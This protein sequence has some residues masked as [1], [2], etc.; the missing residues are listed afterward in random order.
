MC[1]I[2]SLSYYE[3]LLDLSGK[4]KSHTQNLRLRLSHDG[5]ILSKKKNPCNLRNAHLLELSRCR[6]KTYGFNM[7]LLKGAFLWN[8]LPNDF[9]EAK[10]LMHFKSKIWE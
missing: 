10:S 7:I 3:E 5:V 4:K 1:N 9:K 8:K 6:T 2:K